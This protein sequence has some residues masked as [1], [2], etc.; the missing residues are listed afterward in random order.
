MVVDDAIVVVENTMR[1][2]EAGLR[3]LQAAMRAV[4]EVSFTLVAMSFALIAAFIP[5]L[6]MQGV[7]GRMFSEF[8]VTLASA[9]LISLLV[10]LTLTP[11]L[12]AQ[13]LKPQRH[14]SNKQT[15]TADAPRSP[16]RSHGLAGLYPA[17]LGWSLRHPWWILG[18]FVLAIAGMGL[19]QQQFFPTAS[20]IQDTGRLQGTF[21]GDQNLSFWAMRDKVAQFLQIIARDP[22]IDTYYE[23]TGGFGGGQ[24]N[25][26]MLNARL[27]PRDQRSVSAQAVVDRLRPQLERVAGASLRLRPQQEFTIGLRPGA[28]EYQYTLLSTN[29]ADL[30]LWSPR[31]RDAMAK[32]PQLTDVSSDAQDKGLQ[33][34]LVIDRDA[35]S[36]LGISQQQ[37]DAALNNAFGQRLVSTIYEP[38]NQ[39]YVV[40]T[41]AGRYAQGPESLNNIYLTST[42]NQRIPLASLARW[43]MLNTPLAV[44]HEGQFAAATLSFNL[45]K[46]VALEEASQAIEA[47]FARLQPPDSV[48]GAFSGK[49]KAFQASMA[50]QPW[51]IL[52][53]LVTIY[54]V[55][56]ML[57]ESL[58][59]PLT[60]LSTLPSAGIG[61][62][63]ALL[64]FDSELTII[65]MIGIVLLI[66]IVMKNAI[67]MIDAA[68]TL[69]RSAGLSA[70][71]AITQA[72]IQRLRPILMTTFAAVLGAVPL[73]L[74]VGDGAEIRQP[75][76]ISIVGGLLVGQVLTLLT[77]PVIYLLLDRLAQ[78]AAR[79]WQANRHTQADYL[80]QES[81]H[82]P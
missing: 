8:S 4:H 47:A 17:V 59:H 46:G 28:A 32:L 36:R 76:G 61:A 29:I 1:H 69:R 54:L 18:L 22:D 62:L 72:A 70:E 10:S 38:L 63:L 33:T 82:Q 64:W 60:I 9:V 74:G 51:L 42:Q 79:F 26:G 55:L 45:A 6:F 41:V 44:N 67:I 34:Q 49:A 25:T 37:I 71:Q 31:L 81:P 65:A 13:L 5:L 19:V 21:E 20:R 53:A 50:S 30:R 75:L 78:A 39:Y 43:E 58:L 73:L 52:T 16:S 3:P 7:V 35:A 11:V 80:I 24:S 12:C 48:H 77:T 40:L 27:K 56:G 57:Y 14:T 23:Y 15:M 2:L 68:I 66:G